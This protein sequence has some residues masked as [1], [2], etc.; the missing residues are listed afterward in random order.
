MSEIKTLTSTDMKEA[1]KPKDSEQPDTSPG[2]AFFDTRVCAEAHYRQEIQ[3]LRARLEA[4]TSANV[5]LFSLL[6][7]HAAEVLPEEWSTVADVIAAE[8]RFW[9]YPSATVGQIEEEPPEAF[10]PYLSRRRLRAEWPQ[11]LEHAQRVYE[12]QVSGRRHRF[13]Y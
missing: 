4:Q 11:L 12:C 13:E 9:V 5:E 3:L 2:G 6:M 8:E 1:F 7:E 10:M